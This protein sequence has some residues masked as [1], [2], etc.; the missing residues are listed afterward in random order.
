MLCAPRAF[1]MFNAYGINNV[2]LL[3]GPFQKWEKDNLKVDKGDAENVWK[4]PDTDGDF[5]CKFNGD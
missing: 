1:W 2:K 3:N 4:F 5:D